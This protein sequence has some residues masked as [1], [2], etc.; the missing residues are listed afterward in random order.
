MICP[1]H[2]EQNK[3]H[4]LLQ[5]PNKLLARAKSDNPAVGGLSAETIML[6][7]EPN[8]NNPLACS[9]NQQARSVAARLAGA[10][11][12]AAQ[13]SPQLAS[14]G[15]T[16][17]MIQEKNIPINL[18]LKPSVLDGF[19]SHNAKEG[20]GEATVMIAGLPWA[21]EDLPDAV[22]LSEAEFME[23]LR[24]KGHTTII[25]SASGTAM[26][27]F[28][29][30]HGD[31]DRSVQVIFDTGASIS[32]W[33]AAAVHDGRLRAHLDTANPTIITSICNTTTTG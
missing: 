19:L 33:L 7:P 17:Y 32:L 27:L 25:D 24:K 23:G 18:D 28:L 13:S 12:Q 5:Y 3:A 15:F 29:D 8:L 1:N 20:Q 30:M 26:Y 21:K 10:V 2:I 6:L 4:P 16:S 31:N 9:L 11:A 14:V 22:A